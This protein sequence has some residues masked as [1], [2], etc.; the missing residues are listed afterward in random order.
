MDFVLDIKEKDVGPVKAPS[1]PA[2]KSATTG[3][4]E[5]KKRTRVSA[6]K[7]QRNGADSFLTKRPDAPEATNSPAPAPAQ[8]TPPGRM[9][10]GQE[11]KIIDQENRDLLAS[12]S[13]EQI[14]E[15]RQ[16]LLNRLDPRIVQMF[17]RRA[18]IEETNSPSPFDEPLEADEDKNKDKDAATSKPEETPSTTAEATS[19][20]R[21]DNK[22]K[23]SVRFEDDAPPPEPPSELFE[24]A[25]EQPP[26]PPPPPNS[27]SDAFAPNTTHFP[28]AKPLPD[29]DPSDP[30]FLQTL[31][32]KYFPDLPADPSKLAWMAP[33]PTPDSLAD[34]ESPYY[35]GQDSLPISALRFDFKGQL[36]AP[37]MSR[38]IPVTQG[39]HHHGLAPEAAGYTISEL[40]ILARSA[41]PAQRCIAFQ[42]LGRILY[43]LGQG[44]WGG[45]EGDLAK[46]IWR[47]AQENRVMDS[48]LEAADV[49]EGQGHRGSRAY[50]VEALWL[51]EKGGWKE[52]F[53]G[54]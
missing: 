24:A 18:N 7:K 3:F 38:T 28:H 45:A 25:S 30:D 8:Q 33:L 48:L 52:K 12:M 44:V 36:L 13:P 5:H 9:A 41:V 27:N 40:G 11:R 53:Q 19:A 31:H 42:T 2:P 32:S 49:P 39:L 21:K 50:A 22:R 54:R 46:G 23:K 6:F 1:F 43:K 17:L 26:P 35:P 20:F 4:P 16:E 29:L 47:T 14:E 10:G 51:F 37:S 15:E 34:R